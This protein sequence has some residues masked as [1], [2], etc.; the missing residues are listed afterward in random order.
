[1][2]NFFSLLVCGV[3]GPVMCG[4]RGHTVTVGW[5][6]AFRVVSMYGRREIGGQAERGLGSVG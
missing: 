2:D 5:L 1:M 6:F 3:D 4:R